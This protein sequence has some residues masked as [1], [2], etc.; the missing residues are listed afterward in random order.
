MYYLY[1]ITNT[2]N[3]KRYIGVTKTPTIRRDQHLRYL[4]LKTG[5]KLVKAA[6][7]KYGVEHFT[8]TVVGSGPQ[9][10]IYALEC[11]YISS[12]AT[13][14]PHG[15]N[16]TAGGEGRTEAIVSDE[17]RLKMGVSQRK[18]IHTE[19][20]KEH[21]R[22]LWVG[23]QH[24]AKTK[25]KMRVS[26]QQRHKAGNMTAVTVQGVEYPA[27]VAAA[28]AI[29]MKPSTLVSRFRYYR[30]TGRWPTGWCDGTN[31]S[32]SGVRPLGGSRNLFSL[33]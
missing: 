27:I 13:M 10:L 11:W 32:H 12:W 28:K 1:I 21:L 26:A 30:K 4:N 33:A 9:S 22:G 16:L 18:R 25:Q 14:V 8:F 7:K 24:T 23:R 31:S 6:V 17:T 20:E 2:V 3:G 29:G 5:S 19:A 15:Y